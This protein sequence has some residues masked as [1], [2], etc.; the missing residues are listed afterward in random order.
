M[1][2]EL[3]TIARLA[4]TFCWDRYESENTPRM[5]GD[6]LKRWMIFSVCSPRIILTRKPQEIALG[7]LYLALRTCNAELPVTINQWVDM[8]GTAENLSVQNI[9]GM[10]CQVIDKQVLLTSFLRCCHWSSRLFRQCFI[11]A[12]QWRSASIKSSIRINQHTSIPCILFIVEIAI[13]LSTVT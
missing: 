6:M 2:P 9:R 13:I 1:D 5:K 10:S 3:S 7:C 12:S 11:C 8:W 4:W